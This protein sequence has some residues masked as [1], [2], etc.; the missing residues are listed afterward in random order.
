VAN[1]TRRVL[2]IDG[3]NLVHRMSSMD[4]KAHW[5]A[6][7]LIFNH[8]TFLFEKIRPDEA[9]I[10]W[11][12]LRSRDPRRLIYEAYKANRDELKKKTKKAKDPAKRAIKLF[13]LI[14]QNIIPSLPIHSIK[15]DRL[16][17]D[18]CIGI[19]I[20]T[21]SEMD[22]NYRFII[23]STDQDFYQLTNEHTMIYNP[24]TKKVLTETM[25]SEKF[26]LA[27]VKNLAWVKALCGDTADNIMGIYRFGIKTLQK[28]L[29]TVLDSEDVWTI[30][31]IDELLAEQKGYNSK[32]TQ[33]LYKIIQL[34]EPLDL[35]S[36]I[37][38]RD[39]IIYAINKGYKY[40]EKSLLHV[41]KS[42]KIRRDMNTKKLGQK[43]V[44]YQEFMFRYNKHK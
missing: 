42:T 37:K 39:K 10:F 16:E 11:E 18:D 1:K 29:S 5:S 33:N 43:L 41:Y 35:K 17:A 4:G 30:D 9:F 34:D 24:Q 32:D 8:I 31:Q 23:V 38:G 2:L 20:H 44:A 15:I 22:D 36:F 19:T 28:K 27:N 25:L 6:E 12:G 21:M 40:N 7:S 26:G 13:P 14:E 3:S